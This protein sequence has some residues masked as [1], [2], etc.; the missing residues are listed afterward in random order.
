LVIAG[1]NTAGLLAELRKFLDECG[2]GQTHTG[3]KKLSDDLRPHGLN[4]CARRRGCERMGNL[5]P[6]DDRHTIIVLDNWHYAFPE[7]D[8]AAS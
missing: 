6:N 3:G 7:S 8:L 5:T 2:V 1:C 4:S